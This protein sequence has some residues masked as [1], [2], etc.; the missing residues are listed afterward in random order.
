MFGRGEEPMGGSIRAL[1]VTLRSLVVVAGTG[2]IGPP[3]AGSTA[4]PPPQA[5]AEAQ[6]AD[7][8]GG[9]DRGKIAA[10]VSTT[11]PGGVRPSGSG[12]RWQA[13]VSPF[14]SQPGAEPP[15]PF[16]PLRPATVEDRRRT[17]AVR[18]Y[19]AARA[20]EDQRRWSDAVALLQQAATRDPDSLAIA[21]RL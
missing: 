21:R 13:E 8:V 5:K 7:R 14:F 2:L 16:V 17:E 11:A 12:S 18:L 9:T 15:R 3:V 10:P 20:L 4:E 19:S 1:R 6:A